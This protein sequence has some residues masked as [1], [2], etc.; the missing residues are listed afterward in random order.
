M[1]YSERLNNVIPGGAHTYSRGDDQY[2]VNAPQILER[3]EGA[4]VWDPDGNKF[5]DYGMAL[6]A[7]NVGY[8]YK[9][10][11]DAAFAEAAKGN[12]LTRANLTE[13]RAAELLRD[14]IPFAEMVKFAKNGSTVT[15]AGLKLARAF[16]GR[17]HVAVAAEHPFF[18][19]DDWYIGSTPL[20]RGI[21]R[22]GLQLTLKFKYNDIAS[23]RRLFEQYPGK[24]AAV[25]LE[26]AVSESP[27]PECAPLNPR[28]VCTHPSK[29]FLHQLRDLCTANGTV[30]ILDEMIT[31]F[32]WDLQGASMLYDIVPD[33]VTYGKAMANGFSVAALAGKKEIME[34]GGIRAEGA[35]RVFL[36]STTHGAEMTGLGAFIK[37]MEVL[38]D[39]NVVEH[40]W[41]YGRDLIVGANSIAEGLGIGKHFAFIGYPCSPNYVTR[42]ASGDV[43]LQFRTLFSQEMIRNRVLIPWVALSLAHGDAELQRSLQAI[44]S[45]LRVYKAALTEGIEKYLVGRAIR[46]VFRKYN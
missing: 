4:Y 34:L 2:P 17:S 24:I 27:C 8:G 9:P 29:N 11:N 10:I 15:T 44:E 30:F 40:L 23:V 14:M 18:S 42:D 41:D 20:Q 25:M 37:T 1:N 13:L 5:L 32:R 22:E 21:P 7:V 26:P 45:S 43:S 39:K 12:Q 28:R 19:Y 3:G 33:L 6:R 38:K 36:I 46:P 31:G 16:T 35:E